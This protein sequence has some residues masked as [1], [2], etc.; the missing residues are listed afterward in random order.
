MNGNG[1]N[2][3]DFVQLLIIAAVVVLTVALI[4]HCN[5]DTIAS[6]KPA[7]PTSSPPSA[8]C[9]ANTG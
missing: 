7:K 8:G 6:D 4:S 9:S 3:T 2:K 5:G 1:G